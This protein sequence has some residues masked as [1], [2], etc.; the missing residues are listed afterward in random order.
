MAHGGPLTHPTLGGTLCGYENPATQQGGSA[1]AGLHSSWVGDRILALARPWH[2]YTSQFGIVDAFVRHNIGL[3]LN[4]QE[5]GEHGGCG[6]GN[7][8]TSGFS[9]EPD[10]F[11]AAGIAAV[12]MGWRDMSVP[13]LDQMLDIVQVS[14]ATGKGGWKC[15]W[16]AWQAATARGVFLAQPV[17]NVSNQQ[18]VRCM[19]KGRV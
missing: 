13:A 11:Q 5:V 19:N 12:N 14:T 8:S 4:L 7:L 16:C 6:P 18:F 9:Y 2:H 17:I 10:A 1:I 15:I 3:L